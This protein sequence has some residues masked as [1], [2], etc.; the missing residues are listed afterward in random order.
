[1]AAALKTMN[2]RSVT[3]VK[4]TNE[5]YASVEAL[6]GAWGEDLPLLGISALAARLQTPDADIRL[7]TGSLFMLGDLLRALGVV[8]QT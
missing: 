2:P 8:P 7:V 5:R 6:R 1:M 4:G 3:L